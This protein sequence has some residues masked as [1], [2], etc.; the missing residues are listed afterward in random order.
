MKA[1]FSLCGKTTQGKP[2]SGPV[3]A[4]Y[5]IA[6]Y[7]RSKNPV[8]R[9]WFFKN[10]VQM[11][12]AIGSPPYQNF[13]TWKKCIMQNLHCNVP[14]FS[15]CGFDTIF[16]RF[17]LYCESIWVKGEKHGEDLLPLCSSSPWCW[18]AQSYISPVLWRLKR[19]C[20]ER[21]TNA[22]WS[23][24]YWNPENLGLGKQIGQIK[25]RSLKFWFTQYNKA[26]LLSYFQLC[27]KILNESYFWHFDSLAQWKLLV[28]VNRK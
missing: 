5:G 1:G 28:L 26:S 12:R 24:F 19:S 14:I 4:L 21:T 7:T 23:F 3:L 18:S 6:V 17:W 22:K 11:D 13:R 8:R 2:W 16:K 9:T 15:F 20:L 10:Q 27:P 25:S